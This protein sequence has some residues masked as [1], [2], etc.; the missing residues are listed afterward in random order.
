MLDREHYLYLCSTA[1]GQPICYRITTVL[2][3]DDGNMHP[4]L[5]FGISKL[6]ELE[7]AEAAR[8][9]TLNLLR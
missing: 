3:D 1:V 5:M 9:D 7:R 8:K 6:G 4:M 2:H